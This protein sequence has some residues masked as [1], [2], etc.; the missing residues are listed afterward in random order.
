MKKK[1]YSTE[2]IYIQKGN[3]CKYAN[4]RAKM[5]KLGWQAQTN[6][7][8]GDCQQKNKNEISVTIFK[9]K[10]FQNLIGGVTN[11]VSFFLK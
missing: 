2:I 10:K 8:N 9:F 4:M 6:L 7:A 3:A 11:T 5:N 1:T